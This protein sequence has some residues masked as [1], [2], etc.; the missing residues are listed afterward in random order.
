DKQTQEIAYDLG[1]DDP[2]YFSRYFK[3]I[4]GTSPSEFK[5]KHL[6]A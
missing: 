3:K 5:E 2:A 1:F 6:A 4:A